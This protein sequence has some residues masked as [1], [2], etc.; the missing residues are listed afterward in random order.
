VLEQESADESGC[1]GQPGCSILASLQFASP[2]PKV[3]PVSALP[4]PLQEAAHA[5][6]PPCAEL[7]LLMFLPHRACDKESLLFQR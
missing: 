7:L 2:S 1:S 4:A 3:Y 5:L 6:W